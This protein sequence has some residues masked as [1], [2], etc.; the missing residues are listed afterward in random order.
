MA[1]FTCDSC[2]K[3]CSQGDDGLYREMLR[4]HWS[5]RWQ[6]AWV[7]LDC[8]INGKAG[9]Q[10]LY[11]LETNPRKLSRAERAHLISTG[12]ATAEEVRV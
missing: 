1:A 2:N 7:C 3:D 4:D 5:G 9:W 8:H 10:R 11:Y 12:C 6:T